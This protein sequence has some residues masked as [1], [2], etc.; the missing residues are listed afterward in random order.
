MIFW[1]KALQLLK[2]HWL[3]LLLVLV[4]LGLLVKMCA[5]G[6]AHSSLVLRSEADYLQQA[7][8]L[9]KIK[10][11][12]AAK[13]AEAAERYESRIAKIK[14]ENDRNKK[15]LARVKKGRIDE[16]IRGYDGDPGGLADELNTIF[17]FGEN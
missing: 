13:R 4:I 2:R 17:G 10:E 11:N 15:E 12:E 14:Q 1:T 3:P 8:E 16:L 6:S 7:I 5:D 9:R